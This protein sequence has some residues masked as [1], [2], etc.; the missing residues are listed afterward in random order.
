MVSHIFPAANLDT[1]EL[2]ANYPSVVLQTFLQ[3]NVKQ[4]CLFF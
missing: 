1:N 2:F 3:D 4:Y